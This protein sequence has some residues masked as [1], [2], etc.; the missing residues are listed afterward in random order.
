MGLIG[1]QVFLRRVMLLLVRIAIV[2]YVDATTNV[3]T[4]SPFVRIMLEI[5]SRNFISKLKMYKKKRKFW[6]F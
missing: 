6:I 5:Y 3:L 1:E 4:L 2:S